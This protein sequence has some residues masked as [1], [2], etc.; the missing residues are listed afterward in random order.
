MDARCWRQRAVFAKFAEVFIFLIYFIFSQLDLL[1][2]ILP[3]ELVNKY[4][5]AYALTFSAGIYIF[6]RG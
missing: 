6:G 5:C 4:L 2:G 3:M 1:V